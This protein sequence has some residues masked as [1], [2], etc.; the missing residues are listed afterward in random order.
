MVAILGAGATYAYRRTRARAATRRAQS[1]DQVSLSPRS[2]T[3]GT[4]PTR[5]C[6]C[7]EP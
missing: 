4:L 6:S 7:V 3:R 1:T 5:R 2:L